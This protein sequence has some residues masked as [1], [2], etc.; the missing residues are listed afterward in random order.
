MNPPSTGRPGYARTDSPPGKWSSPGRYV[1][2]FGF[3]EYDFPPGR[4]RPRLQDAAERVPS[5]SESRNRPAK[6]CRRWVDVGELPLASP[7][8]IYT[9]LARSDSSWVGCEKAPGAQRCVDGRSIGLVDVA[10]PLHRANRSS[11]ELALVSIRVFFPISYH[12]A[13][14]FPAFRKTRSI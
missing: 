12:T 5:G 1:L 7:W 2:P 4:V 10:R 9:T 11:G 13:Q 3:L 6:S 8:M 14:G